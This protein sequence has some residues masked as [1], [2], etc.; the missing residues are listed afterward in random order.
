MTPKNMTLVWQDNFD[1]KRLDSSK[2]KKLVWNKGVVNNEVQAYV[3]DEETC[4]T[5]K[6]LVIQ[7][8]KNKDGSWKSARLTTAGLASWKYGYFEARIKLPPE[9]KGI[10]PAFWMMSE[11]NSYGE[12]PCSGEID[13][14]E[15]SP[16]TFNSDVYGTVHY[17]S[18]TVDME[19]HFWKNLIRLPLE[20]LPQSKDGFHT[21]GLMWTENE[22]SFYY[23]GIKS[24]SSW[25]RYEGDNVRWPFDKPFHF[26]INLAMGGTLGGEIPA[27]LNKAAL[28]VEYV[29]VWQ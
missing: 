1:N 29:R 2:W 7:A 25:R 26:I 3:D 21:Y 9:S 16:A 11:D 14:L 13:I 15:Y 24:Q 4:S 10:W 17:G 19:S 22:I 27:Q 12:W 20:S 6:G 18:G 28:E 23:D 5:G 8:V